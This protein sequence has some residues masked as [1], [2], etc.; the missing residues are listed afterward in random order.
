MPELPK[1]TIH[2]DL[3]DGTEYDYK[4]SASVGVDGVFSIEIPDNLVSLTATYLRHCKASDREMFAISSAKKSRL[5]SRELNKG[6]DL[7]CRM[8]KQFITVE[9][10][11]DRVIVYGYQLGVSFWV[12]EKGAIHQNGYS[13]GVGS[14]SRK[15]Q[16]WSPSGQQESSGSGTR[17]FYTVGFSAQ[18]YDQVT[19]KRTSGDTYEWHLPEE[20]GIHPASQLNAFTQLHIDNPGDSSW[21]IT[22]YSDAAALFFVGVLKGLCKIAYSLDSFF[23]DKKKLQAAIS[24]NLL[25]FGK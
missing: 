11:T 6:V 20:E 15:G 18:V 7:L 19:H 1:Q 21:E 16:W 14:K 17:P 3:D 25:P 9:T 8:A 23:A 10:V 2:A 12:D 24:Q 4:V 22:P 13:A 5:R